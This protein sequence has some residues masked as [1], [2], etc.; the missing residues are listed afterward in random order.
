MSA[1]LPAGFEALEPFVAGWAISGSAARAARR[2]DST[3]AEREAFYAAA[4]DLVAPGLAY[5][6]GKKLEEFDAK[7][8]RLM[9]LL[10]SLAHVSLAVEAL[11]D[12]EPRHASLRQYMHITRTPAGV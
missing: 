1:L 2:S 3:A 11:G 12:D 4:K 7:D 6:D 9:D 10:L 8:Q 5:L